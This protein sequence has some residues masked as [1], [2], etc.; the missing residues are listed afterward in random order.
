MVDFGDSP[1]AENTLTSEHRWDEYDSGKV[2]RKLSVVRAHDTCNTLPEQ[3]L[4]TRTLSREGRQDK[5][6]EGLLRGRV[7][8]EEWSHFVASPVGHLFRPITET[9][10][11]L[12][13]LLV[14]ESFYPK[15]IISGLTLPGTK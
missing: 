13:P 11:R 4:C 3:P 9:Y 8:G 7:L 14:T 15:R 1:V 10:F 5:G 2:N 12:V 6:E